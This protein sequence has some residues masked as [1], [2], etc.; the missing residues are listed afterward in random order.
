MAV[1]V[2]NASVSSE[3]FLGEITAVKLTIGL[4]HV[5][6]IL[7]YT[8]DGQNKCIIMP[9]MVCSLS[10]QVRDA[11]LSATDRVKA[12][13]HV[14]SGLSGLHTK[15]IVYLDIKAENVLFDGTVISIISKDIIVHVVP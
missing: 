3:E 11:T 4:T 14:V 7:G 6:P 10:E 15:G 13:F 1:K 8:N 2:M 5:V 9:L 12:L